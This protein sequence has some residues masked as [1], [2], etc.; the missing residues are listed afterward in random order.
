MLSDLSKA[1]AEIISC[2]VEMT[3]R[4]MRREKSS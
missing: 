3:I 1:I 2:D 4:E